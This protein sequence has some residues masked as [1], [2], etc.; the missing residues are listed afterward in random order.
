MSFESA[1]FRRKISLLELLER[2]IR[3]T[4]MIG[5]KCEKLL[6]EAMMQ[7]RRKNLS[8]GVD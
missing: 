2:D 1:K 3:D 7:E 6:Q 5:Y 4:R 8:K